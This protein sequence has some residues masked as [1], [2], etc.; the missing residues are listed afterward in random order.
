[1]STFFPGD[2]EGKGDQESDDE[3]Y[4]VADGEKFFNH[5]CIPCTY[6]TNPKY[7]NNLI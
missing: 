4:K 7:R 1:M 5:K 3:D 6:L 2:D